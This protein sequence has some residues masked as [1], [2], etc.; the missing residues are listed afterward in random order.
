MWP[1]LGPLPDRP[2]HLEAQSLS[3][4][5]QEGLGMGNPAGQRAEEL[6]EWAKGQHL[7]SLES[8]G[9]RVT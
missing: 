6:M 3:R 5:A 2:D 1:A 8:S 7:K 9:A 4:P